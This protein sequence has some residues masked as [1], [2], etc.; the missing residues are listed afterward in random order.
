MRIIR[1]YPR[2]AIGDGGISAAIRGWTKASI[3]AGAEVTI[4]CDPRYGGP[5][6]TELPFTA[7]RHL[8]KGYVRIP[9]GMK[10]ALRNVDVL[11]LHS[12][13]VLYNTIAARAARSVGVPYVVE[14][15]GAY[16]P[17]IT[18]RRSLAKRLWWKLFERRLLER[19]LAVHVFFDSEIDHLRS[20]GYRGPVVIAPN[21]VEAVDH[22]SWQGG[23]DI[24]WLGRFDPEHKGLDLLLD[25]LALIDPDERPRLR[26][27]GP[28]WRGQKA[29]FVE[30][31]QAKDLGR[32]VI[33]AEP[34]YAE[35]K[36]EALS[37]ARGFVYPSK[38]EGFGISLAEAVSIGCPALVTPY[39]FG[40]FLAQRDAAFLAPSEAHGLARGLVELATSERAA[41]VGSNGA[42]VVR[43]EL[44]WLDVAGRWLEQ[45]EGLPRG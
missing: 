16:D 13:W 14:P 37:N 43:E 30:S 36:W 22:V 15:R 4:A 2:A 21:G 27:H 38:W 35:A 1:Y 20:L 24:V 44:S 10:E 31:V 45:V 41:E 23:A 29:K 8:G 19:S 25:A 42:R 34:V 33:V 17:H 32:W 9:V 5:Q 12:G 39:P 18:R 40:K 3:D 26:L 28:D 7:V 11:V 6:N